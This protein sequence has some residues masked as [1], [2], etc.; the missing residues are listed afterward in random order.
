MRVTDRLPVRWRA[1]V[2]D[3]IGFAEEAR[4]MVLRLDENK[5]QIKI[6]AVGSQND[7]MGILDDATRTKLDELMLREELPNPVNI[8]WVPNN[9]IEKHQK[10]VA[11]IARTMFE[12]D[13]LPQDRV[14]ICNYMDEIWVPAQFNVNTFAEAGVKPEK[15]FIIPNGVDPAKYSLNT[16]RMDW[17]QKKE[18][19]FLSVFE[20][21]DRKGWDILLKAYFLEFKKNEDV[22]LVLKVNVPG[23]T[24]IETINRQT[25]EC[26]HSLGL[27]PEQVPR[28]LFIFNRFYPTQELIA[29][30]KSCNAFVLP[31]RGEGWGLPYMEAM[32]CGLP[33]IGTR[34]SGQLEFMDD[35][36]SYL[37]NTEGLEE[38]PE[39]TDIPEF[40]GHRWPKPSIEHTRVLMREVYENR[41]KA[42]EKG[43]KARQEVLEKWS[44]RSAAEKV[45]QRLEKYR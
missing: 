6:T 18:F 26:I 42:R 5:F 9:Y 19:N 44:W 41:D 11:N 39:T 4:N 30:Y 2:Y 15:L 24:S 37:I 29:L 17:P 23:F 40:R 33:T 35:E 7:I 8:D 27:S 38:I 21:T 32:A 20:W 36:N 14:E 1:F 45:E 12:T 22:A 31:S 16:D 3:V 34:W 25:Q 10:A 28:L 43:R 13:R